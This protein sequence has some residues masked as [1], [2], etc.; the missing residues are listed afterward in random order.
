MM[1]GCK[2]FVSQGWLQYD[3]T[4]LSVEADDLWLSQEL[5][6]DHVDGDKI[7]KEELQE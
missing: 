4:D 5:L 6:D 3:H 1:A 2:E 7:V